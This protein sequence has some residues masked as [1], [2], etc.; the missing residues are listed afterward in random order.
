MLL[1]N[2]LMPATTSIRQNK[3][4]SPTMSVG[5]TVQSIAWVAIEPVVILSISS[6]RLR[7]CAAK[8][9][10]G[11]MLN[12]AD[13]I[14]V[15]SAFNIGLV[16]LFKHSRDFCRGNDLLSWEEICMSIPADFG[17]ECGSFGLSVDINHVGVFFSLK[18]AFYRT[19]LPCFL[20]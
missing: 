15:F 5:S 17:P 11:K 9:V 1:R 16:A 2:S 20:H 6:E 14:V 4:K 19:A 8:A 3:P 18:S 10:K 12:T 13:V 7:F